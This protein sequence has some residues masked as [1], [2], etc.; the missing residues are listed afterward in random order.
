MT[1][2]LK[3]K[4]SIHNYSN[5]GTRSGEETEA[6]FN[7]ILKRESYLRVAEKYDNSYSK[8]GWMYNPGKYRSILLQWTTKVILSV[9]I[10]NKID[11]CEEQ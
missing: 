1:N 5:K 7:K 2:I 8:K 11:L 6:L 9:K 10:I 3:L 4:E